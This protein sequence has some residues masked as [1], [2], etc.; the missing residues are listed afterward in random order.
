MSVVITAESQRR[1]CRLCCAKM[2]ARS[3]GVLIPPVIVVGKFRTRL[4]FLRDGDSAR[5]ASRGDQ[6]EMWKFIC[7]RHRGVLGS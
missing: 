5:K 3:V 7:P 6:T 2:S 4:L 1:D